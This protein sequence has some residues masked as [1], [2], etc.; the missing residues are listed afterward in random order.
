MPSGGKGANCQEGQQ[1][2]KAV[3]NLDRQQE[4]AQW[5][6]DNAAQ[7]ASGRFDFGAL[8]SA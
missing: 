3:A 2:A 7:V 6:S 5:S 4:R 1:E 8:V